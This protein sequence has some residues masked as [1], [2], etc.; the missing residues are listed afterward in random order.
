[1]DLEHACDPTRDEFGNCDAWDAIQT[2]F[3]CDEADP[4]SCDDLELARY[5]TTYHREGRWLADASPMLPFLRSG[6]ERRFHL[7]GA[8]GG[9][10]VSARLLFANTGKGTAPLAIERLW[11]GGSFD[12]NYDANHPPIEVAVP[13]DATK[14]ELVVVLS[15]HGFGNDPN[16]AEFCDHQHTFTVGSASYTADHPNM[17]DQEGCLKQVDQ[18]T[19]PNQSGTWWFE[20]S[21]W[22]P[23]KQVDP[24]VFD[25]TEQVTPGEPFTISY[26]TNYG[27]GV[28]G[29]NIL[30]RSWVSFSR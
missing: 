24:W 25:I 6:G 13:A 19:V 20:R 17:G 9:H 8:R 16:C 23:G 28:F 27:E 12:E 14:A 5:I 29:G 2:L 10:F 11:E 18:G 30:L 3:V 22:C 15:G 21:S 1:M 26:D 4:E 7:Q